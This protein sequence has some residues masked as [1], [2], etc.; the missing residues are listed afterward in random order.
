[1]MRI[2]ATVK[3]STNL[4]NTVIKSSSKK[5]ITVQNEGDGGE[6]KDSHARKRVSKTE[7]SFECEEG[8]E[9]KP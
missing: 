4:G 7:Q 9:S 2:R 8:H 1:M 5:P 6:H 3:T